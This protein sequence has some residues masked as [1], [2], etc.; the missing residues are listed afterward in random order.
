MQNVHIV[1]VSVRRIETGAGA[2]RGHIA[3]ALRPRNLAEP[4]S[5]GRCQRAV[6]RS[7]SNENSQLH[8]F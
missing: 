8:A 6:L 3:R 1:Y 5:R 2:A 7:L 4:R